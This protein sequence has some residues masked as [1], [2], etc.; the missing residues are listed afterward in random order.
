LDAAKRQNEAP[1]RQTQTF[2]IL[3]LLVWG[4]HSCPPPLVLFL[5]F[6][7]RPP[8]PRALYRLPFFPAGFPALP[9]ATALGFAVTFAAGFTTF[10]A[11]GFAALFSC[12]L[13][14]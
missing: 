14:A 11:T 8:I 1:N 6:S 2:L 9:F 12:A 5:V 7:P 4:G 3:K 10:F 13:S